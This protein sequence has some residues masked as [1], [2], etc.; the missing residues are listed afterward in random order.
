MADEVLLSSARAYPAKLAAA[1]YQFTHPNL[2]H[3][4][5]VILAP[6]QR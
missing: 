4:L 3:A 6:K 2:V 5:P 1:G